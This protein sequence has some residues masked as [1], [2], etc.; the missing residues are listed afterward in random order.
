MEISQSQLARTRDLRSAPI[1]ALPDAKP[2]NG[3]YHYA[4][5]IITNHFEN[6]GNVYQAF[7]KFEERIYLDTR[8]DHGV[9]SGVSRIVKLFF[10]AVWDDRFG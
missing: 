10:I 4:H 9:R 6:P 1:E 8:E 5:G 7:D 2:H 3:L